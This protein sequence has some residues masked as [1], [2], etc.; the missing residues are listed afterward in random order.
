M[1]SKKRGARYQKAERAESLGNG[2]PRVTACPLHALEGRVAPCD[3]PTWRRIRREHQDRSVFINVPY[4]DFYHPTLSNLLATVKALRLRPLLAGTVIGRGK[5][6]LCKICELIQH[7]SVCIHDLTWLEFQNMP[8]EFG[9]SLG[10]ARF[11]IV[12]HGDRSE[13]DKYASNLRWFDD[14]AYYDY[15]KPE[16]V[17]SALLLGMSAPVARAILPRPIP[18][19]ETHERAKLMVYIRFLAEGILERLER[20]ESLQQ[21]EDFLENWD[22]KKR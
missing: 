10:L 7:C 17:I 22:R 5:N 13:I 15:R 12:L 8:M 3:E 11:P 16:T 20:R 9:M 4:G 14:I 18:S 21:V 2:H 6:R 1:R 19:S